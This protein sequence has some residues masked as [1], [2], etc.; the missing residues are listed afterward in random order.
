VSCHYSQIL[1]VI[2]GMDDPVLAYST[3]TEA[4][5]GGRPLPHTFVKLVGIGQSDGQHMPDPGS[6]TPSRSSF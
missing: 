6:P 5:R 3:W 1:V 2:A 4:A